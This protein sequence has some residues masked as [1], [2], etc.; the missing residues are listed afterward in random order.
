MRGDDPDIHPALGGVGEGGHHLAADNQIRGGDM[1]IPFRFINQVQINVLTDRFIIER[2]IGKGLDIAVRGELYLLMD[3]RTVQLIIGLFA[4]DK[5]PH[6]QKH[7]SQ[8]PDGVAFE[9]NRSIFPVAVDFLD[10]DI[11]VGKVDPAGEAGMTVDH[12]DFPVVAVIHPEIDDRDEG[13]KYAGTDAVGLQSPIV[14]VGK[15]EDASEI[16][17]DDP[18]VY[19]LGCLTFQDF[20]DRIPHPSSFNDKVFK[21]DIVMRLFQ[22]LQHPFPADLAELMVF[23]GGMVIDRTERSLF[24]VPGL[25]GCNR[26]FL[27]EFI[28]DSP[29]GCGETAGVAADLRHLFPGVAGELVEAE[30][31]IK[32]PA[33]NRKRHNQDDPRDF[34]GRIRAVGENREN[35]AEACKDKRSVKPRRL[36]AEAHLDHDQSDDLNDEQKR[37]DNDP[38]EYKLEYFFEFHVTCPFN[39]FPILSRAARRAFSGAYKPIRA[40]KRRVPMKAG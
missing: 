20:K 34:I 26:I 37:D 16:V 2:V 4:A 3:M 1:D 15:L 22:F 33:E 35:R 32:R 28:A 14:T 25:K 13:I 18:D 7:N 36:G 21:E 39:S 8:A 27:R 38:P 9:H 24:D 29:V 17:V 6:G 30:K 31:Q 19:P 10:V 11:F 23:A 12:A 5:V 40:S